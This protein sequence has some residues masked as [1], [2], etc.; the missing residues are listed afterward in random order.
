[1]D[2][3]TIQ[4]MRDVVLKDE[5]PAMPD[6]K[7]DLLKP[8]DPF[9][10]RD[11]IVTLTSVQ[12]LEI[13]TAWHRVQEADMAYQWADARHER[14]AWYQLQAAQAQYD[15]LVEEYMG[16]TPQDRERALKEARDAGYQ[17][18]HFVSA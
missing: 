11:Q 6:E 14:A 9:A 10:R 1:M 12:E 17:P 4:T 13:Q 3:R 8:D 7:P 2:N 15:A 5:T 18:E 16:I